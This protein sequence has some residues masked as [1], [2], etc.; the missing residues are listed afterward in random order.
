MLCLNMKEGG[1]GHE[2]NKNARKNISDGVKLAYKNNP[3]ILIK[4]CKSLKGRIPWNKG[5]KTSEETRKK[6]SEALKGNIV[7]IT[8]MVNI[9]MKDKFY[10]I[11]KLTYKKNHLNLNG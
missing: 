10:I 8:K 11:Y 6:Q 4:M 3:E 2:M 9:T 7:Y 5:L 1:W